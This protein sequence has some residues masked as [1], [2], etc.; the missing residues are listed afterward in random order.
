MMA[1]KG[2]DL[3]RVSVSTLAQASRYVGSTTGT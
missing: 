2:G 1:K 3:A